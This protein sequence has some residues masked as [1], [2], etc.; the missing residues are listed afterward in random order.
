MIALG[1]YKDA[2][3]IG[4]SI[5]LGVTNQMLQKKH[6]AVSMNSCS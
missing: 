3:N 1:L 6:R 5:I 4:P 2:G